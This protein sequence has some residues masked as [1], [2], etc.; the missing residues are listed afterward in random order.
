MPS[1]YTGNPTP[2]LISATSYPS[3]PS[4]RVEFQSKFYEGAGYQFVPF[5][6]DK[7][8]DEEV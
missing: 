2:S 1:G 7:N 4:S 3:S 6:L 8:F 5:S